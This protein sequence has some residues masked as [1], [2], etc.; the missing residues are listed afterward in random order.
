MKEGQTIKNKA[1]KFSFG[2]SQWKLLADLEKLYF[3]I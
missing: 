2:K 1:I 3:T